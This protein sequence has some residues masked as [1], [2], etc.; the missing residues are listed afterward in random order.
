[1][2]KNIIFRNLNVLYMTISLIILIIYSYPFFF[3]I[4]NFKIEDWLFFVILIIAYYMFDKFPIVLK[5]LEFDFTDLII[6]ISYFKFNIYAA[7]WV[8][9]LGSLIDFSLDSYHEKGAKLYVFNK[10][11]ETGATT[12]LSLFFMHILLTFLNKSIPLTQM[13]AIKIMFACFLFF[14][15]NY[16]LFFTNRSVQERHLVF[17]VSKDDL[18][19]LLIS[20]FICT[21]LATSVLFLFDNTNYVPLVIII[22]VFLVLGFFLHRIDFLKRNSNHL[23]SVVNF[24]SYLMSENNLKN[25]FYSAVTTIEDCISFEF[26]GIYFFNELTNSTY[27]VCFKKNNLFN[28]NSFK[29][30]YKKDDSLYLSLIKGEPICF[31]LNKEIPDNLKFLEEDFIEA[32]RIFPIKYNNILKGCIILS[33]K[34]HKISN[35]NICILKKISNQLALSYNAASNSVK[36][37]NLIIKNYEDLNKEIENIIKNK[38][39]FTLAIVRVLN[40]D[41]IIADYNSDFYNAVQ[42]NLTITIK[43]RLSELDNTLYFNNDYIFIIF[44]ITDEKNAFH[45]MRNIKEYINSA[46]FF[47]IKQKVNIDFS[48]V[49]YPENGSSFDVLYS[50]LIKQLNKNSYK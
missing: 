13:Y 18:Y 40:K 12:T 42:K 11:I 39:F 9:F 19:F 50:L 16:V 22:S 32:I 41:E 17:T 20:F 21:M 30:D 6:I 29:F 1:M 2:K 33:L 10:S 14:I 24:S 31:E 49:Q 25:K 44:N 48:M 34:N 43:G 26:C 7:M 38:L 36:E 28:E 15:S 46:T 5:N 3:K 45:I 8:V 37:N 27:P 47:N 35:S 23:L 4:Y